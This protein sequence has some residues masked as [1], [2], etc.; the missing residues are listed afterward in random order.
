MLSLLEAYIIPYIIMKRIYP[1]ACRGG[2]LLRIIGKSIPLLVLVEKDGDTMGFR[3]YT[4]EIR[5]TEDLI[6][7]ALV[8]GYIDLRDRKCGYFY[9]DYDS[10]DSGWEKYDEDDSDDDDAV[11]IG[12]YYPE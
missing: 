11:R 3:L 7:E 6:T 5:N 1:A 12:R 10:G 8:K 4:H 9:D 2:G